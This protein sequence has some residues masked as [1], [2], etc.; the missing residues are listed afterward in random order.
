MFLPQPL[1]QS[2]PLHPRWFHPLQLAPVVF[3]L[4]PT[5]AD[6][7]LTPGQLALCSGVFLVVVVG[8]IYI[9]ILQV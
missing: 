7:V 6:T 1:A 2:F 5:G 4:P 9:Y 8:G 3:I